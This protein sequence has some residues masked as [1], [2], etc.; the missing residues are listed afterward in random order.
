[1]WNQC[2]CMDLEVCMCAECRTHFSNFRNLILPKIH[3][4][5]GWWI[6]SGNTWAIAESVVSL[7]VEPSSHVHVPSSSF[8]SGSRRS[9]EVPPQLTMMRP[10][11]LSFCLSSRHAFTCHRWWISKMMLITCLFPLRLSQLTPCDSTSKKSICTS[12]K[13]EHKLLPKIISSNDTIS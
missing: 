3:M 1:M 7:A 9:T 5:D 10:P 13:E 12:L 11:H 4:L 2:W 6:T 8:N